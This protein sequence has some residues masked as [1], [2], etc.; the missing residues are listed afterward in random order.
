MKLVAAFKTSP[1]PIIIGKLKIEFND[2]SLGATSWL[3]ILVM[4]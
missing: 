2:I 1:S 4:V 3:W